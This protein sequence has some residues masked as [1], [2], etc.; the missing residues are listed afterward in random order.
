MNTTKE[1]AETL[2]T[3]LQGKEGVSDFPWAILVQLIIAVVPELIKCLKKPTGK[4]VRRYLESKYDS[5]SQTFPLILVWKARHRLEDK[6]KDLNITLT[7][8]QAWDL[9]HQILMRGLTMNQ[10]DLNL[11]VTEA[12]AQ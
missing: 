12:A 3:E 8:P 5:K 4:Q 6:A 10:Q 2:A 11:I 9:T 7:T 1:Q